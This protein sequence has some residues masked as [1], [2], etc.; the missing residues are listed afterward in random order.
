MQL[1]QKHGIPYENVIHC[2]GA[3]NKLDI[4]KMLKA[5]HLYEDRLET[6]QEVHSKLPI[7]KQYC[8]PYPYNKPIEQIK[9]I[10]IIRNWRDLLHKG[11][12]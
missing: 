6:M 7:I 9:E 2:N 1:F 12:K 5:T 10:T 3:A 4:L 11:E 8:V